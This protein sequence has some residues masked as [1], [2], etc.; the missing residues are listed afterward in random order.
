MKKNL[1]TNQKLSHGE[2]LVY[3]EALFNYLEQEDEST[4]SEKMTLRN[5]YGKIRRK[6][7]EKRN[8]TSILSFF[9]KQ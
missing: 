3:A 8:Q 4:Q 9:T 5:L 1:V 6:E 2:A 7:N